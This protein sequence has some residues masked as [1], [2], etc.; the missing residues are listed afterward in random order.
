MDNL[1]PGTIVRLNFPFDPPERTWRTAY[2]SVY[3]TLGL[4]L[5]WSGFTHGIFVGYYPPKNAV[6]YLYHA[7]AC[8][9]YT[10]IDDLNPVPIGYVVGLTEFVVEREYK[11]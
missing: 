10:S 1:L 3:K 5:P 8:L 4:Q 9:L 11:S 7:E 2:E 6:L